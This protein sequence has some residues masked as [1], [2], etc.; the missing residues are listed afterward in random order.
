MNGQRHLLKMEFFKNQHRIKE[1]F[2]E[3][4][5][6]AKEEVQEF[7]EF[8]FDHLRQYLKMREMIC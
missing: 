1:L 6:A 2:D 8:E 3:K 5:K 4:F 7:L